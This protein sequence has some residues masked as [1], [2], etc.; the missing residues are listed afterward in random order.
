[1][2]PALNGIACW[3]V[4]VFVWIAGIELDLHQAWAHRVE[5]GLSAGLALSVAL[6]FGSAAA[7]GMLMFPGWVG[8]NAQTWQFVM[9]IGMSCAVTA[10]PIL[11]L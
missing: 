11:I 1:M 7:I 10:L 6:A 5:S 3:A 2:I 9:G 4:M 8:A